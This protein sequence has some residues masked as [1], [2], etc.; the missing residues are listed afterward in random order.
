M[1]CVAASQIWRTPLLTPDPEL[2]RPFPEQDHLREDESG[3]GFA[4]RMAGRNGLAFSDLT[5]MLESQGHRYLSSGSAKYLAYLFGG[6]PVALMLATPRLVRIEGRGGVVFKGAM[7]TRPYLVRHAWPRLCPLCLLESGYAKAYWELSIATAC[8]RHEVSL[9]D[10]CLYCGR[11]ISWR[12]PEMLACYCGATFVDQGLEVASQQEVELCGCLDRKLTKIATPGVAPA[13]QLFEGLSL[14]VLM[15]LIWSL[16]I[17]SL[18]PTGRAVPGK[19]SRAPDVS[20]AKR[21]VGASLAELDTVERGAGEGLRL[22]VGADLASD[23]TAYEAALLSVHLPTIVGADEGINRL[24]LA[25]ST[26]DFG[27]EGNA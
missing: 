21:L 18:M 10:E 13:R 27:E 4:L 11:P 24:I 16:G 7:L 14:N 23:M 3:N 25:Q 9:I 17:W 6:D 5:N 19:V 8:W 12:R 20:R 26:L 1:C 15:R 22:W 2:G